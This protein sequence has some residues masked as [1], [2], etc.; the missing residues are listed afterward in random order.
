L[1]RQIL[2]VLHGRPANPPEIQQNWRT[3]FAELDTL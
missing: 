1:L 2:N 3:A